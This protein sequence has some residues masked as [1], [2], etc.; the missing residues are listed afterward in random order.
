MAKTEKEQEELRFALDRAEEILAEINYNRMQE[1]GE[2]V[3]KV[4]TIRYVDV[5]DDETL[6]QF[7]EWQR[8][9]H[10]IRNGCEYLLVMDVTN[11]SP[12]L[13]YVVNVSANSVLCCMYAL[14]KLLMDKF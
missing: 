8:E 11:C 6:G 2:W 1:Y 3:N 14:F 4:W 12:S 7:T 10:G 5:S 9:Y 13:L